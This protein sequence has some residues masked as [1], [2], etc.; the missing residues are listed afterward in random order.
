MRGAPSKPSNAVNHAHDSLSLR[1]TCRCRQRIVRRWIGRIRGVD[2]HHVAF[3]R[4]GNTAAQHI[5]YQV[6][7]RIDDDNSRTQS[8]VLV[9]QVMEQGTLSG[10]RASIRFRRVHGQRAAGQSDRFPSSVPCPS[11]RPS[12]IVRIRSEIAPVPDSLNA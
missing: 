2:Q 9:N 5:A 11:R 6:A 8:D 7:V 3:A 12:G 10:A 1:H 4:F